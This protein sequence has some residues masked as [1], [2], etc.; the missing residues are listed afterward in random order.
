VNTLDLD[1][2]LATVVDFVREVH[3]PIW[4]AITD[5]E[6]VTTTDCAVLSGAVRALLDA[7]DARLPQAEQQPIVQA[8][9]A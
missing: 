2:G 9:A 5:H 4:Q 1:A 3:D 6:P 8:V 7:I